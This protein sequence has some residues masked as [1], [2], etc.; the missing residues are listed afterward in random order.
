MSSSKP[1]GEPRLL[2]AAFRRFAGSGVR[3]KREALEFLARKGCPPDEAGAWLADC[4]RRGL[5][6]DRAAA[7][8]WAGH[9]ARQDYADAAIR[10]KLLA[11]G[12][13]EHTIDE[14]IA[15][16]QSDT[17]DDARARRALAGALRRSGGRRSPARLARALASRGFGSE[18]V[19]RVLAASSIATDSNLHHD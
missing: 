5:I 18:L 4:E 19:E 6:D 17:D 3:S 9:W 2:K 15:A 1:A 10:E 7:R 13:T 8:L 12:F 16:L 11:K 14:S